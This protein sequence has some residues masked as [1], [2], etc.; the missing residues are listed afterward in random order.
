MVKS[1]V[2]REIKLNISI[3]PVVHHIYDVKVVGHLL[4][5]A[6]AN[7]DQIIQDVQVGEVEV[8]VYLVQWHR[9]LACS[10]ACSHCNHNGEWSIALVQATTCISGCRLV[11]NLFITFYE[12]N[13]ST[14][15]C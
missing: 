6:I 12:P 11:N 14:K 4:T 9:P 5:I 8:K 3:H 1:S 10:N 2:S 7:N 15:L 13:F